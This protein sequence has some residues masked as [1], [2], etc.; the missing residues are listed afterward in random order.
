MDPKLLNSLSNEEMIDGFMA[1]QESEL[2]KSAAE[3]ADSYL[4]MRLYEDGFYRRALPM[5]PAGKADLVPQVDTDLPVIIV[6][7]EP[8]ASDAYSVPLGTMPIGNFLAAPKFRIMFDRI[9]SDRYKI[10]SL[11]LMTYSMDLKGVMESIL[12]KKIHEEEDSKFI[13]LWT[14]IVSQ[15]NTVN[16]NDLRAPGNIN[17]NSYNTDIEAAQNIELGPLT[18]DSLADLTKS[19]PATNRS[20]DPSFG[21]VNNLTVRD[22]AKLNRTEVGGDLSQQMFQKG[23]AEKEIMGLDWIV[24]IKKKL[25]RTNTVFVMAEPKFT[26]RSYFIQDL[27]LFTKN[28]NIWVEF[29]AMEAIGGAIGNRASVACGHFIGQPHDW[30]SG[31]VIPTP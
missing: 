6:E 5:K 11:K 22:V 16:P 4:R 21:L 20:L 13:A 28:E 2:Y 8:N 19:L 23:F 17:T 18:R 26:G 9:F 10:D 29:W 14:Y 12:L 7:K 24:T 27:R 1:P 3:T 30:E 31:D 15:G 25:V